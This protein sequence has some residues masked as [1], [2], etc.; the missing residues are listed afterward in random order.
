M[1]A[2][3]RAFSL[4]TKY[5]S[6]PVTCESHL[7]TVAEPTEVGQGKSRGNTFRLREQ[8]TKRPHT[9]V[10]EPEPLALFGE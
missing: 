6:S 9:E 3:W 8:H 2:G 4:L 10:I 7:E 1:V 5:L